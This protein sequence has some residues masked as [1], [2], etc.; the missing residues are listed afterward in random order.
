MAQVTIPDN[1]DNQKAKVDIVTIP[2]Q[3]GLQQG[4]EN[5][6]WFFFGSEE[7]PL[8]RLVWTT[9]SCPHHL[10]KD[11]RSLQYLEDLSSKDE[12]VWI[13][14]TIYELSKPE[15]TPHKKII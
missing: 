1:H 12:F 9:P 15:V 11:L 3:K 8:H 4:R 13:T 5:F 2:L 7:S 10:W 6:M 14:Q